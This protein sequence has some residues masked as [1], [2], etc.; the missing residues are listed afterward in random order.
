MHTV[1]AYASK[2]VLHHFCQ[3]VCRLQSYGAS[4]NARVGMCAALQALHVSHECVVQEEPGPAEEGQKRAVGT[5]QFDDGTSCN[6][7]TIVL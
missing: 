3:R 2:S 4:V 7:C 5:A 1:I 6:E